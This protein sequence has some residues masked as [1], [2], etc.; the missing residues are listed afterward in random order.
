[1]PRFTLKM[2]VLPCM[3]LKSREMCVQTLRTGA[4]FSE[5]IDF[6][7]HM[8]GFTLKMNVFPSI[9]FETP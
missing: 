2:N 5:T 1:M 6:R 9:S 4:C 7:D 8:P 3:S